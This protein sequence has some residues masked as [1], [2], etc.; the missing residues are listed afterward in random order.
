MAF[1]ARL[2]T[3]CLWASQQT[4]EK[5]LKCILLLNRIPAARVY[6]DLGAALDAINNSGKL[7]IDLTPRTRKFMEHLD[8]CGR[9]RY[10]EV[11]NFA[12]GGDIVQLDRAA[13]ELRRY[14]T[15]FKAPRQIGLAK[16]IAPQKIRIEGGYL[17]SVIDDRANPAREPLLWHN[18]FLGTRQRRY[19]RVNNWLK[20]SNAPLYLNPQIL[21]EVLKYVHL[22]K[23]VISAHQAHKK[24]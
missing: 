12:F 7:V 17:E 24:P 5:Y 6:H 15:Q 10:L 18:A 11:S 16:G 14:C 9:F 20:A 4:I 8:A 2:A 21:N 3:P 1:R 22:P 23:D 13:W 19:V